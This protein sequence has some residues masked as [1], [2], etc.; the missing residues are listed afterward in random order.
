MGE[1]IHEQGLKAKSIARQLAT[2]SNEQKNAALLAMADQLAAARETILAANAKDLENVQDKPAAFIDRMTLTSGGVDVMVAGIKK[3]AALPDPVGCALKEWQVPSGLQFKRVS[4]PIGVIAIIY[5]SRPNVTADAAALCL[6]SGNAVILRGGSDCVQS[7]H[8]IVKALQAGLSVVGFE[9]AAI[10]YVA[11]QNRAAVDTLLSLDDCIDVI[12]PRGGKSLI[13]RIRS[14][15][16][17]P[18]FSH[19]DGLCH[20]YIHVD[21][22]RDMAVNIVLN[23]KLRRTGICGATESLLVDKAIAEQ[24]LPPLI[25][26][27]IEAGCEIR[28]DNIT[29]QFDERVVPVTE[30]DW[31][32]EYLDSI[33]SVKVV[34]D[35]HEAIAH[36]AQYGSNHTDAIITDNTEAASQFQ[37]QVGSAIVMHNCSTQFADGG[38][39]GM[40]AE[41]GIATG[42]LH[43]RGPVGVCELT[44]YKTLVAGSG[45]TRPK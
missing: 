3:I 29:Q 17:I 13:E 38:E 26:Q 7:N 20:T 6:K 5:E 2:R 18:V 39:F 44:T 4:I 43:A 33:L 1:S 12:V 24:L 25:S 41:I 14:K 40:G 15:S 19:L 28:G 34:S 36:I 35:I 45:Q 9:P 22:N 10:Q 11:S 27:L 31:S 37:A 21:A 42:K 8:A 32:T 16:R 23:A 30:D